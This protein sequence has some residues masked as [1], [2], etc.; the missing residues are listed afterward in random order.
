MGEVVDDAPRQG[1]ARWG[2]RC[3]GRIAGQSFEVTGDDYR[4]DGEV[5]VARKKPEAEYMASLLELAFSSM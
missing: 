1:A 5:R 3:T 2:H 4:P